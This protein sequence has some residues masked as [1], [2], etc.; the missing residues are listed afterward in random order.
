[1][2]LIPRED[3]IGVLELVSTTVVRLGVHSSGQSWITVGGQQYL[4]DQQ[5]DCDTA[6]SGIGGIDNGSLVANSMYFV[7]LV[8]SGDVFGL[9]AS[10]DRDAPSGFVWSQRLDKAFYVFLDSTI[11][12]LREATD[13][14]YGANLSEWA[15][16]T[17]TA[18]G[19][20]VKSSSDWLASCTHPGGSG[21]LTFKVGFFSIAPEI[22]M[23]A[24]NLSG[25]NVFST[26]VS[27][28]SLTGPKN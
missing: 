16:I 13:F 26:E 7:Y 28:P 19:T 18:G 21:T 12:A 17:A 2:G 6:V 1:M 14:D 4:L 8:R 25:A 24:R 20:I 27:D 23:S 10:L 9:V 22:L 5:L 11:I 15:N 3:R